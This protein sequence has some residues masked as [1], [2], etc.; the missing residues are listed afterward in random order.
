MFYE[1]SQKRSST[2]NLS[3]FF[4]NR[5]VQY[6]TYI[7]IVFVFGGNRKRSGKS[8]VVASTVVSDSTQKQ[9]SKTAV[10]F[11]AAPQN[12]E[13]I[14]FNLGILKEPTTA[15]I[16]PSM[17][18]ILSVFSEASYSTI[19]LGLAAAVP[20]YYAIGG[21]KKA[22]ISPEGKC[23]LITGC[24]TGFGNLL[25]HKLLDAGYTVVAACYTQD[26]ATKLSDLD[27][28]KIFPVVADLMTK[29]GRATVVEKATKICKTMGGLYAIVNNAG[30]AFP[31]DVDW[32]QP[33]AYEDTM[34]LNFHAPVELTYLLLPLIKKKK[35]RVI[36]VSSVCGM[37]SSPTNAA[38]C[39]S[40]HALESWS[41]CLR[42]E[43]M[44]WG[45][46][47][48]IIQPATMKTPIA[49]TYAERYRDLYLRA[50][51]SRKAQYGGDEWI[52]HQHEA[53]AK[54]L[55]DIAQDPNITADE[56]VQALQLEDPP[57]RIKSGTMAK[58]FFKPISMLSD[59]RRDSILGAITN[60]SKLTPRGVVVPHPPANKISHITITVQNLEESFEFY[61]KFGF[62]AVGE[63][64]GNKQ[65]LKSGAHRL[66]KPL[67]LLVEDPNMPE[68]G[69]CHEIGQTRLCLYTTNIKSDVE[70]LKSK[71]L[72][73]CYPY[74]GTFVA[75]VATYRSPD[76]FIVYMIQFNYLLGLICRG[77]KWYNKIGGPNTFHWTVNVGDSAKVN[78]MFEAI[79]FKSI[80]NQN[81]DQVA[82][83]LLPAFGLT[84]DNT[85]IE[86]IR[87]QSLPSD[88]FV[89]TAMEWVEPKSIKNGQELLN[90][91]SISVDNVEEAMQK[92]KDVGMIVEE[93][94]IQTT[95]LPYYGEV[96]VGTAYLEEGSNP[97]E[98]VAF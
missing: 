46:K 78:K 7:V 84:G 52:H 2:I 49:L 50:E 37:V 80:S 35:G 42:C 81:K 90:K 26:A 82:E 40:K 29:E 44:Q 31:G 18:S 19:G 22:T 96:E 67:L 36:N 47:V 10:S 59:K 27:S 85:T 93:G 14:R 9:T 83:G 8:K 70:A 71:G 97:I 34:N 33:K 56:M 79:G 51:P 58:F 57:T 65:F 3:T 73:V 75:D 61:E 41:D 6:G 20:L 91:L 72:E 87:M 39:A 86:H 45:V 15:T 76:G 48:V 5:G 23:V 63:A 54:G 32:L 38:Y 12:I 55:E 68:R 17:E 4:L 13:S 95:T 21:K 64:E 74:A 94:A 92:A 53:Q 30:V 69:K 88:H 77:F 98:F 62:E 66:W 28:K 89:V 25:T 11:L 1:S 16:T 24:D 60:A 43:M